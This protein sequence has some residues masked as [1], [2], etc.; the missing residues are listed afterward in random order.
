MS[1]KLT[2]KV[3]Y[4]TLNQMFD[5][6]KDEVKGKCRKGTKF[7]QKEDGGLKEKYSL[8]LKMWQHWYEEYT[9][10]LKKNKELNEEVKREVASN[11]ELLEVQKRLEAQL[12]E[13]S[14]IIQ[15][16]H[17]RKAGNKV[18]IFPLALTF[19]FY[20]FIKASAYFGSYTSS[21]PFQTV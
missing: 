14:E 4:I 20:M 16:L 3:E 2:G 5:I 9:K 8:A 6:I 1:K 21:V 18:I 11:E 15:T 17:K 10:E 12:K 19:A 13:A 7:P